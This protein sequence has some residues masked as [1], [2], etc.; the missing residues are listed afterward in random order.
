MRVC[1]HICTH[2]YKHTYFLR[3]GELDIDFTNLHKTNLKTSGR[4][5]QLINL[6]LNYDKKSTVIK[7]Q[8]TIKYSKE[9]NFVGKCQGNKLVTFEK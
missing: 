3:T 6:K 7:L 9:K 2:T 5:R 1:I 4:K 8:T